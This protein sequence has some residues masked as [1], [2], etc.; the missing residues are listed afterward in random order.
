QTWV[1]TSGLPMA[2]ILLVLVLVLVLVRMPAL[3]RGPRRSTRTA[4][5]RRPNWPAGSRPRACWRASTR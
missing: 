4:P 5:G 2:A 3:R 1:L